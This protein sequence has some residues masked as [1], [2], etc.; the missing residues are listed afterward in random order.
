MINHSPTLFLTP[1]AY[2][3]FI[4]NSTIFKLSKNGVETSGKNGSAPPVFHWHLKPRNLSRMRHNSNS[5]SSNPKYQV[6]PRIEDIQEIADVVTLRPTCTGGTAASSAV[7]A[8]L[9]NFCS[10]LSGARNSTVKRLSL[11]SSSHQLPIRVLN[12]F[13][14]LTSPSNVDISV[15]IF[16]PWPKIRLANSIGTTSLSRFVIIGAYRS[17][18]I[19]FH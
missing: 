16:N 17:S 5:E 9:S 10:V 19:S 4:K 11:G 1:A 3:F 18:S 15:Y 7:P 12:T 2:C 6:R 14:F 13:L 8:A